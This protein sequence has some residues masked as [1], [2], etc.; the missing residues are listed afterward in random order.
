MARTET[1]LCQNVKSV[2]KIASVRRVLIPALFVSQDLK[3]THRK[4][5]VVSKKILQRIEYHVPR[6]NEM[7]VPQNL[8][9]ELE[10]GIIRVL[11]VVHKARDL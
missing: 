3:P 2:Q 10:Q 7:I 4:L 11:K 9:T 1:V 8:N 6:C 5:S